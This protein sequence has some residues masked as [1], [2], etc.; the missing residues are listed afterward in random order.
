MYVCSFFS[1]VSTIESDVE[2]VKMNGVW[3]FVG[4]GSWNTYDQSYIA[5]DGLTLAGCLG[6]CTDKRSSDATYNGVM[7]HPSDGHCQC[8]KNDVGHDPS[9]NKDWMHFKC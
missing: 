8:F 1:K 4:M 7:F 2:E 3:T 5:G 6:R 9:I